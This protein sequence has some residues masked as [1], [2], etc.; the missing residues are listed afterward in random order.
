M[1]TIVQIFFA[2]IGIGV[3]I[4]IHEWG[5]YW[6]ARRVGMKVDTFSIGFG[7]PI[8][9]WEFQGV[10]WQLGWFL[11]GGYVKIAAMDP[12][13]YDPNGFYAKRPWDRI[14]VAFAGPLF[15]LL[16]ALVFFAALWFSGGRLKPF[17]EYT[18]RLGYLDP[19]STLWKDG[20]RPGDLLQQYNGH[21]YHGF[22]ELVYTALLDG[23]P[24]RLQGIKLNNYTHTATPFS[25]TANPYPLANGVEGMQTYGILNP[26][27]YLF[28]AGM[29]NGSPLKDAGF[30]PLDRLLWAD[31]HLLFSQEQLSQL[32]NAPVALIRVQRGSESFLHLSL[33]CRTVDLKL[34]PQ[35]KGEMS[36]WY[37][38]TKMEMPF[39]EAY[40]LPYNL[41]ANN[42]VEEVL[43]LL[44]PEE[45]ERWKSLVI[46]FVGAPLQV[47]D[48]IAA[49]YDTPMSSPSD[50]MKLLQTRKVV[51][52]VEHNHA[53]PPLVSWHDADTQYDALLEGGKVAQ[54][55][56][57][58]GIT[59]GLKTL[60]NLSVLAPIE[61]RLAKDFSFT[62]EQRELFDQQMRTQLERIA[63][64]N[65]PAKRA[66][67][68]KIYEQAQNRLLLGVFLEDQRVEYNP[69]PFVLF[70]NV[71]EEIWH[72]L[73]ALFSGNLN[74]KWLS[75]PI[76]VVQVIQQGWSVGIKEAVFWM[77]AISI[78]LGLMNLLPI[79]V[80]D[81]GYIVLG[82]IEVITK[83]RI[84]P[85]LLE[86][87]IFPFVIFII[88]FFLFVTYYDIL[89]LF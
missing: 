45:N 4:F 43:S 81:G 82:L 24:L 11:F 60:N 77:G 79:P 21:T 42:E 14:K 80:L 78:N 88:G 61:P 30:K 41:S 8:Y 15:N 87:L 65:D 75:G 48:R 2:I 55:M 3:L 19:N 76:G 33:K 13:Q 5:H 71:C 22:K 35:V 47:G 6:M 63:Q 89:R 28:F 72:T 34:T 39:S 16:L 46:P 54:L 74:P 58:I 85:K 29:T 70:G 57:Q 52:I 64:E 37:F 36:D 53:L 25:L 7:R 17:S 27:S 59:D 1:E 40:V 49:I 86:R 83:K 26:A 32:V 44:D 68:L 20:V 56:R 50:M 73:G 69:N 66:Y 31:G 38:D 9:S 10:K 51:V 62:K 67:E 18:Q 23:E 84:N 12:S